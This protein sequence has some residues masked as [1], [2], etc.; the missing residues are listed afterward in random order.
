MLFC[1]PQ[2]TCP[3]LLLSR[4]KTQPAVATPPVATGRYQCPTTLSSLTPLL[5]R[6][7]PS[8][9]N[10]TTQRRRQRQDLN[11][12]SYIFAGQPDLNPIAITNP[13]YSPSFPQALPQQLFLSTLE[14]N[15]QDRVIKET[16]RFH[17]LFLTYSDK[18]NWSLT[19]MYS[20]QVKNAVVP[21]TDSSQTALAEAVSLWLRD[22]RAG[23]I[24]P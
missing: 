13:E 22:C 5:L 24:K 11:Y 21:P 19:L 16:Q 2:V 10:R 3:P 14:Q 18:G 8:Y 6:D 9:A 1:P 20:R 12:S 7:L 23:Q 17:W 4:S 15:F